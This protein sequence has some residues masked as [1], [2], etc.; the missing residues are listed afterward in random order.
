MTKFQ[1]IG[2]KSFKY[3]LCEGDVGNTQLPG[4]MEEHNVRSRAQN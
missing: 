3:C 4:V 2:T 1:N